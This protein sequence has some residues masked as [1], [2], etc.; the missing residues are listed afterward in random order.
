MEEI[1][2]KKSTLQKPFIVKRRNSYKL[3]LTR[4]AL[5]S[6]PNGN[7][8]NANQNQTFSLCQNEINEKF[9]S[10]NVNGSYEPGRIFP[11]ARKSLATTLEENIISQN[12]AIQSEAMDWHKVEMNEI[13]EKA[14]SDLK[15]TFENSM[16]TF[17]QDLE[18]INDR[19]AKDV[20]ELKTEYQSRLADL[21]RAYE[22]GV[23]DA[24]KKVFNN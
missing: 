5:Q 24:K 1:S 3:V 9:I 12:N 19:Y 10:I 16:T 4:G 2:T 13:I 22:R 8:T 20:V 23:E 6:V 7:G 15:T 14:T 17:S 11:R 18:Q 21:K